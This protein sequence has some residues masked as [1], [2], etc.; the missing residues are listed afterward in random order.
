[1]NFVEFQTLLI[2]CILF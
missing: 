2:M 1:M